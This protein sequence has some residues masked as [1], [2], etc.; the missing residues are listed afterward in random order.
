MRKTVTI[1]YPADPATV[2]TMLADPAFQRGR[3]ARLGQDG[4]DV[5]VV[6]RGEGFAVTVRGAVPADRLPSAA[7]R[8]VRG[9]LS[10]TLTESWGEPGDGGRREGRLSA[11]I[12][13]APV[14]VA[15]TGSM[16]S[17]D[18]A[19]TTVVLDLSLDVT[20]PLVG[21]ALEDRAMGHVDAVVAD[22]QARATA[23]LAS[24]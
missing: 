17:D 8:F 18:G 14:H 7:R 10:L 20:V 11:E 21:R 23:W 15:A 24:H 22:E 2:A 5:D 13:G 4:L 6:T 12:G 9:P 3:V 19:R 1:T 16:S